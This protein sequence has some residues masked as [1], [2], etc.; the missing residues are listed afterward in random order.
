MQNNIVAE[1]FV[2][3]A[4]KSFEE[5]FGIFANKVNVENWVPKNK[6]DKE[7][8]LFLFYVVQLDYATKS[9]K[10]YAGATQLLKDAPNFFNPNII[11]SLT[12]EKLLNICIKYLK[13]RYP[14]EACRRYKINSKKLLEEYN[15]NPLEILNKSETAKEALKRT[16]EFRG[17]GNKTGNLFLRVLISVFNPVFKDIQNILPPVDIH[18]VRIAYL[19]GF[20]ET[21]EMSER[22]IN[23]VKQIWGDACKKAKVNWIT[24][25]R[26]LWLLGSQGKPK[27]KEDVLKL[28]GLG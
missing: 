4:V 5:D 12:D 6:S 13:P 7:R 26:A 28:V 1:K 8:S 3:A 16:L 23:T 17:Y 18:D 24:F 25:D 9:Q 27:T 14:N 10:L 2:K 15:E 20:T 22:N 21:D 19:L 11:L